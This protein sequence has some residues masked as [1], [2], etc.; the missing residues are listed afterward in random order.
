MAICTDFI[1]DRHACSRDAKAQALLLLNKKK[2]QF[3]PDVYFI[4]RNEQALTKYL[5]NKSE[6]RELKK[7][8]SPQQRLS[9]QM[10]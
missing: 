3:P 9:Y 7:D 1:T 6:L 10:F 4:R 5:D 8:Q 2:P